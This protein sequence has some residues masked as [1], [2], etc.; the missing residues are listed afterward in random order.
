MKERYGSECKVCQ[1]PFT[2]FRWCPGAKMR[3]KKTEICQTCSRAKNICQ[4]CLL[5][6]QYGL[7]VQVRDQVLGTKLEIPKSEINREYFSQTL[8]AAVANSDATEAYGALKDAPTSEILQ[9]LARNSP[10]YRRNR[11]HICSFWVKGKGVLL[12]LGKISNLNSNNL[13]PLGECKRGEE[14]PYRHEKPSD[15]EDPLSDQNIKDRYFG[16][17]DPVAEKLLRRASEMPRPV[18]PEDRSITTLYIGSVG[19]TIEEADLRDHFYQFGEIRS[20]NVVRKSNC[21]FVQYT[22]RAAAEA[23][24]EKSFQKLTIRGVR[25]AIRWGRSQGKRAKDAEEEEAE[26]GRAGSSTKLQKVAAIPGLPVGTPDYFGLGSGGGRN[27]SSTS[28]STSRPSSTAT[29]TTSGG[30][31]PPLNLPS[32]SSSNIYYPSQD[33]SR[34]GAISFKQHKKD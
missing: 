6:L 13:L 34:M 31:I 3:Y 16:V 1:R 26:A 28:A 9:K 24:I 21:A 29:A 15:P 11:A 5:D 8:D 7:P 14:C 19:E 10:Y 33:P 22:T 23:A 12:S 18:P 30:V 4:T 2:T 17:N 27:T 20:V 25:L 32:L